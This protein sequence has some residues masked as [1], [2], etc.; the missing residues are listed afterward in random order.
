MPKHEKEITQQPLTHAQ[1][2]E[3]FAE[4]VRALFP[5]AS[6]RIPKKAD[7]SYFSFVGVHFGNTCIMTVNRNELE[8]E[9][10]KRFMHAFFMSELENHGIS[11][12]DLD[13]L[14]ESKCQSKSQKGTE[15]A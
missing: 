3:A 7:G 12:E 4:K 8:L 2:M 14:L 10:M 9:D 11:T 13:A 1:N 15:H 6:L 5:F